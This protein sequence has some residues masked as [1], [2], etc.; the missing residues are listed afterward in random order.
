MGKE[1]E[2]K[3]KTKAATLLNCFGYIN[4]KPSHL[5]LKDYS[6]RNGVYNFILVRLENT[7]YQLTYNNDGETRSWNLLDATEY[8]D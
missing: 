2:Q 6:H 7:Y 8:V 3:L 1:I 5:T 4:V